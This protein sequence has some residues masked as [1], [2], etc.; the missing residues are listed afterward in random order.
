MYFN[1]LRG[2]RKFCKSRNLPSRLFSTSFADRNR[3]TSGESAP[4]VTDILPDFRRLNRTGATRNRRKRSGT[5]KPL[6]A[7]T[8]ETSNNRQ[9]EAPK[10][11]ETRSE[12]LKPP[13]TRRIGAV[14]R[15][16]NSS[17]FPKIAGA[18]D[19]RL[20]RR[21]PNVLTRPTSTESRKPS[22]AALSRNCR[23]TKSRRTF[24]TPATFRATRRERS[25][26]RLSTAFRTR[27]ALKR[28]SR[29]TMLST[30]SNFLRRS[31]RERRT[32]AARS[33]ARCG[34]ATR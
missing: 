31:T 34:A 1:E 6:K 7:G 15:R 20:L 4:R 12:T 18:L 26:A 2:L 8:P 10:L 14:V 13:E 22:N 9:R 3:R 30:E 16:R 19:A 11:S 27:R 17:A 32:F 25:R 23:S 33:T 5:L 21:P 29:T 24:G 28:F